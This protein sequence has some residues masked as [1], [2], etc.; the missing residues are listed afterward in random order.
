MRKINMECEK[1]YRGT[2]YT[3]FNNISDEKLRK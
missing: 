2:K 1:K 3:A